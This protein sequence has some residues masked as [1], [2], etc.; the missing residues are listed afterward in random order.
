MGSS[1]AEGIGK[2]GVMPLIDLNN[3]ARST[4]A[5]SAGAYES[6]KAKMQDQQGLKNTA[7][8]SKNVADNYGRQIITTV[9][10]ATFLKIWPTDSAF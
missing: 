8:L 6:N 5:P 9:E 2:A 1:A 10:G 3:T 4:T 7:T